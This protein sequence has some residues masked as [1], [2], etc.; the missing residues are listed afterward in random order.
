M[1]SPTIFGSRITLGGGYTNGGLTGK[2]YNNLLLTDPPAFTRKDVRIDFNFNGQS[3]GG[4]ISSG[5]TSS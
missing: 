2:Y 3:P 4:S 1:A 5:F